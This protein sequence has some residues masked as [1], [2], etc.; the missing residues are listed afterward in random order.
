M[1]KLRQKYGN[2]KK[3]KVLVNRKG[4]VL[5]YASTEES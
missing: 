4:D 2:T 1:D 3:L 5:D